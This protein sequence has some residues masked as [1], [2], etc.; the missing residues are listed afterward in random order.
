MPKLLSRYSLLIGVLFSL[1]PAG[2]SFS[3]ESLSL[4]YIE[5]NACPFECCQFGKWTAQS[6]MNAFVREDDTSQA[7]FSIQPGD[8]LFAETGNLHIEKFGKLLITKPVGQFEKGDILL[9]LHCVHEGNFL[10]WKGGHFHEVDIFWNYS[11]GVEDREVSEV[12][13]NPGPRFAGVM[14]EEPSMTWWVKVRNIH[15][16]SGWLQLINRNPY[17]FM[18]EEKIEG[19]DACI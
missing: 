9:A 16:Q 4:P 1:F 14:L 5:K 2:T 3:Q 7:A 10:L 17:C 11:E 19:M 12:L 6:A 15:G 13:K 8:V 18:L